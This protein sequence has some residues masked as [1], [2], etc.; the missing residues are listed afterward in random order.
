MLYNEYFMELEENG[1]KRVRPPPIDC[2]DKVQRFCKFLK[3]FFNSTLTFSASKT[4]TSSICYNEIVI[5]E[6]NLI[7]LSHNNDVLLKTEAIAMRNKF[8]K[9]WDGLLNMNPFVIIAS[10]FDPRKK[11]NLLVFVLTSYMGKKVW[12]AIILDHQLG[13]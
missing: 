2:W 12:K 7:S 11:C 1:L 4:V 13:V 6:K 10:V 9:Y 5:I 3:I 8:K